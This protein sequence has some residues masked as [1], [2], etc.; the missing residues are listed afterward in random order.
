MFRRKPKKRQRITRELIKRQRDNR[1]LFIG[2]VL[3]AVFLVLAYRIHHIQNVQGEELRRLASRQHTRDQLARV[4][5]VIPAARGEVMDRHMQPLISSIPVFEI[6]IDVNLLHDAG[7]PTKAEH[8]T[9]LNRYLGIPLL[10][11]EEHFRE[12]GEGNLRNPHGASHRVVARGV[13]ADIAIPLTSQF[14]HIHSNQETMRFHH[15][16]FFAPQV[17]GFIRGDAFLGLES[18]YNMYLT[19]L[20]GRSFWV[21]GEV[22]EI[23]VRNGFD[24]ITTLDSDIQRIAQST[25]DQAFAE[26]D[27]N[28]AAMIVLDPHT[29]EVLAMAQAPNFSIADPTNPAYTTDTWLRDTWPYLPEN[30]RTIELERMWQNFHVTRAYEQGSVFKPIVMAAAIEEGVLSM[31]CHF[32]CSGARYTHNER[33]PCWG[34]H[35]RMTLTEALYQ[36]CNVAMFYIMDQLERSNFYRYR[37]YFGFGSRTGIDLPAET[38]VSSPLVMYSYAA[39]GPVQLWTSSIGQGFNASTIQI[40]TAYAALIN[41]GYLLEPFIVSQVV[42]EFGNIVQQNQRTV[43]RNVISGTTSDILRTQMEYVVTADLGTGRF[44]RVPGHRIGGKTGTGQQGA[45]D[46]RI[47]TYTYVAFT[48]VQD[49]E[50]LVLMVVDRVCADTYQGAGREVGPR[51]ARFFEELI[52]MRG[53]HPSDGSYALD[54]W[55][56]N[57]MGAALMPDYT[58]QRLAEAVRDLSNRSNGGFQVIGSGTVIQHTTPPAGSQMP[59]NSQVIFYMDQD[60]RIEGQMTFVPNV[61]GLTISEAESILQEVGLP[62]VWLGSL[63]PVAT[64]VN[65]QP[66]TFNV[67]PRTE[68]YN[69]DDFGTP[70]FERIYQQFPLPNTEI[71][72]GTM[73][74]IRAR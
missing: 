17:L 27:A 45:R 61:E 38:A 23:A 53:M 3:S 63:S 74:M 9:A 16:P 58:G 41:G 72:R 66:R 10:D 28:F 26:I 35:G 8:I 34:F 50:F 69:G 22:E 59:Q 36:S 19:G 73:V 21:Q 62:L 2:L 6:F 56:T 54:E 39:L 12:D 29:G 30:Q 57:V 14:R 42:D 70:H 4:N 49:P 43:V 55:R 51:V 5:R 46:D 31:D 11:L 71:E 20:P 18:S 7:N 52:T 40:I 1:A 37:G 48:P 15:D 44:S 24:I 60:T 13:E 47:D 64:S 65:G 68:M 67:E 33:I 32:T 25:V